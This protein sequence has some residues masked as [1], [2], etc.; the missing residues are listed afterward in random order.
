[1]YFPLSVLSCMELLLFQMAVLQSICE[2]M[3]YTLVSSYY[4]SP[5]YNSLETELK[6]TDPYSTLIL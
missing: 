5:A 2:R 1:M 3:T 4:S 6:P